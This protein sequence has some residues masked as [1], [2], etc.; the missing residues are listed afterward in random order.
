M[1]AQKAYDELAASLAPRGVK[2]SQMFGTPVLK[3]ANGKAFAGLRGEAVHFRLGAGTAE[4]AEALKLAGATPFD[5]GMGKPMK[6]W[7]EVPAKHAKH[8]ERFAGAALKL[9]G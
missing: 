1:N 9:L 8:F 5:P 4:H 3:N 2:M 6:D 7:V